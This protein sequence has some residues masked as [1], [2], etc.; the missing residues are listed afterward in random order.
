MNKLRGT[1]SVLAIKAPG[2]GDRKKDML[3][4]IATV[5]AVRLSAMK[6]A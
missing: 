4:D 2:Y 5:V 6:L 1:F 3:A